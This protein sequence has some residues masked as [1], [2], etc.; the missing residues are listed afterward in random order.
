M[1]R[2]ADSVVS[3]AGPADAAALASVHVRAW[4]ETYVSLLPAAYLA[5]MD[6]A[7][8]AA[9]WRRRLT[10]ARPGEAVLLAEGPGD[11]LGYVWGA[12][13]AGAT[14]AEVFTLYLLRAAQGR[15]LGRRLLA[16]AA[17]VLAG[18]GAERLRLWV[19]N[20]NRPAI[21]FY[22]HLGGRAAAERP[23]A[24]FF[25]LFETAYVWDDIRRLTEAEV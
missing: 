12:T 2:L 1:E 8:H 21:G 25:G 23:V 3:P 13:P 18:E 24:G 4:R 20:G 6:V 9:R 7:S 14:E 15:G 5:R 22:G 11:A 17:R 19:L 16:C 10:L